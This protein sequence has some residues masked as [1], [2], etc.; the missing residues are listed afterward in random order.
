MIEMK[1]P[2]NNLY[3][4]ESLSASHFVKIFSPALL[5][6]ARTHELFQPGSVVLTGL[7]GSGK[8]ALLNLLKPDVLIA[9]L[10]SDE[11]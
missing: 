6:E 3:Y 10:N 4:T 9:Y 7:Q 1:N 5:S 2:F 11:P 8:S